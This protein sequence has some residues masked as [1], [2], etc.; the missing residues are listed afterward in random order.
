MDDIVRILFVEDTEDDVELARRELGRDA[1]IV[2]TVISLGRELGFT[3]IAE[4]VETEAQFEMLGD[5]GCQQVQG[6]LM[7]RPACATEAQ[8]L[9]KKRWGRR[10]EIGPCRRRETL[11]I[12][13]VL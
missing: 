9:I 12:S 5:L 4:G 3:V 13:H 8:A 11:E 6:Y 10:L 7:A 2:R 1:A